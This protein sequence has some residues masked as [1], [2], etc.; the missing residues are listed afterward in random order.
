VLERARILIPRLAKRAPTAS[1]VEHV[2]QPPM[3]VRVCSVWALSDPASP[4][5]D[6]VRNSD[7]PSSTPN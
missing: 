4:P 6:F 1:G 2:N 7:R 3:A 5:D